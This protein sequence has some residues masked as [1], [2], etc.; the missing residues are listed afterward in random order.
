V[1]FRTGWDV[2]DWEFLWTP[3]GG[4]LHVLDRNVRVSDRLAYAL[5]W[6]VPQE[7]WTQL[8]PTFT[9]IADSFRAAS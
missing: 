1:K 6:S 5:Y 3:S 7:Q 4:T 2:A 9:V 8:Q